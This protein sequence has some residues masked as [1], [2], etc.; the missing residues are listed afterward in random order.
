MKKVS[1]CWKTK[2]IEC[3]ALFLFKDFYCGFSFLFDF[4]PQ[5][6]SKYFLSPIVKTGGMSQGF[7]EKPNR[8]EIL[9]REKKGEGR[10]EER[11]WEGVAGSIPTGTQLVPL[12]PA[13]PQPYIVLIVI[14]YGIKTCQHLL[15]RARHCPNNFAGSDLL[16]LH[17]NPIK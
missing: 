14:I 6:F 7:P 12:L 5:W 1:L 4:L 16:T 2:Y 8:M 9:W 11:E 3:S 17:N 15:L 10:E 13:C